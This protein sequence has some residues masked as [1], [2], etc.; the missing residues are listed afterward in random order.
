M[1]DL[2]RIFA[3]Q[4]LVDFRILLATVTHQNE[5]TLGETLEDEFNREL[6]STADEKATEMILRTVIAIVVVLLVVLAI[7]VFRSWRP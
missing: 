3:G 7:R 1:D 4:R 6:R 2:L 5:T